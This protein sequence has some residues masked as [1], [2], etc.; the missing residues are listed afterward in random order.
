[1][2]I[3]RQG[4]VRKTRGAFWR[5]LFA[6][7]RENPTRLSTYVAICAHAEHFID[8]TQEILT[9]MK[10]KIAAAEAARADGVA[11]PV[12]VTGAGKGAPPRLAT[13]RKLASAKVDA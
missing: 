10:S 6:I 11:S 4:V 1:V 9:Q 7:R 3:W 2:V 8:Y 5:N 12:A 13:Q